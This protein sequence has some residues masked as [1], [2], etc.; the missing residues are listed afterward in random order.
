MDCPAP[1]EKSDVQVI[2]NSELNWRTLDHV[3]LDMSALQTY[4]LLDSD[5][6]SAL[7]IISQTAKGMA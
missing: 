6:S 1:K 7:E 4:L 5:K 2:T 3:E